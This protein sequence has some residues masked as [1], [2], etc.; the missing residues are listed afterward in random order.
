MIVDSLSGEENLTTMI[1]ILAILVFQLL[2]EGT[3]LQEAH[4]T[5]GM[6]IKILETFGY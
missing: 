1:A 2:M 6:E 3:Q 5:L 4:S